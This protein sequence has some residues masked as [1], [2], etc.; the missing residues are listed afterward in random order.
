MTMGGLLWSNK[1][2]A[3]DMARVDGQILYPPANA[4]SIDRIPLIEWEPVAD[5]VSYLLIITEVPPGGT[6]GVPNTVFVLETTETKWQ[7]NSN[8][9][10][11]FHREG[12]ELRPNTPY[13]LSVLALDRSGCGA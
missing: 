11:F 1:V 7:L 3:G 10:I 8:G 13:L 6:I 9:P 2:K 5:A 12:G 4:T